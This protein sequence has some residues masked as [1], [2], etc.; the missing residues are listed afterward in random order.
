M[1]MG[2]AVMELH[3]LYRR[4]VLLK[5]DKSIIF[6]PQQLKQNERA[7]QADVNH[8]QSAHTKSPKI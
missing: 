5:S 6:L 7:C 4:N 1:P 8:A 2:G 3:E